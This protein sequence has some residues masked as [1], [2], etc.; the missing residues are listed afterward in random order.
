[1]LV[2]R[3]PD[4]RSGGGD[5]SRYQIVD[6]RIPIPQ[7]GL[8]PYGCTHKAIKKRVVSPPA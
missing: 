8:E 5:E 2:V 1:M 6:Y 3:L 4:G 7:Q